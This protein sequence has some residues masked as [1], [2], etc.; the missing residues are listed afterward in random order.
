MDYLFLN[1]MIYHID[2]YD[3]ECEE[4]ADFRIDKI[5]KEKYNI[6]L[7][8]KY[9]KKFLLCNIEFYKIEKDKFEKNNDYSIY[10]LFDKK[11]MFNIDSNIISYNYLFLNDNISYSYVNKFYNSK[12]SDQVLVIYYGSLKNYRNF[13]IFNIKFLYILEQLFE[14]SNI[15]YMYCLNNDIYNHISY[16]ILSDILAVLDESDENKFLYVSY[17]LYIFYKNISNLNFSKIFFIN[18]NHSVI[19]L[20]NIFNIKMSE[21][22]SYHVD[23][24]FKFCIFNEN[25]FIKISNLFPLYANSNN[26]DFFNYVKNLI[27]FKKLENLSM[28]KIT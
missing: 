25:D 3:Y 5:N 17:M 21:K 7:H 19:G 8:N 27:S 4:I 13:S 18:I 22:S 9:N 10:F 12:N 2:G 15:K 14:K 6:I 11:C 23:S 24:S 16:T 20:S 28:I 1:N 26:T